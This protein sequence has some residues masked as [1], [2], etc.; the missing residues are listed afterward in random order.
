MHPCETLISVPDINKIIHAYNFI[1]PDKNP[2]HVV[3]SIGDW[4]A[5]TCRLK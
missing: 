2:S 5:H 1:E 3:G 4:K